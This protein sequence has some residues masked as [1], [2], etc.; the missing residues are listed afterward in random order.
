[1]ILNSKELYKCYKKPELFLN[2]ITIKHL[3]ACNVTQINL[4]KS[5]S[6]EQMST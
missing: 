2:V 5:D 4:F 6:V 3:F 1:M